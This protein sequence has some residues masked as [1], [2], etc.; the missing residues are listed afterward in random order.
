VALIWLPSRAATP[1]EEPLPGE[2]SD[3]DA[4]ERAVAMEAAE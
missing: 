2:L 1:T 4:D 3:R